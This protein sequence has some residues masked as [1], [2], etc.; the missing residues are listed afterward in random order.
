MENI[1]KNLVLPQ[2]VP[3]K[4]IGIGLLIVLGLG[5]IFY[6]GRRTAPENTKIVTVDKITETHH[7]TQVVQQ[8]IDTQAILHKLD[9]FNSSLSRLEDVSKSTLK[10]VVTI[11]KPDGTIVKKEVTDTDVNK[12]SSTNQTVSNASTTDANSKTIAKVDATTQTDDT[13]TELKTETKTVQSTALSSNWRLSA[14]VGYS[15]SGLWRTLPNYTPGLPQGVVVETVADRKLF[16]GFSAGLKVDSRLD[17][18]VRLSKE[19]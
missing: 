8:Q 5:G 4:K 14:G 7:E 2:S 12:K 19:F 10:T 9:L 13:K 3:W 17:V 16:W 11:T 18:G 1:F 6:A 15:V